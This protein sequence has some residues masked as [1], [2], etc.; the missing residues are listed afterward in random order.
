MALPFI[1][2]AIQQ[3]FSK[4]STENYPAVNREAP[5]H[6]RGRIVFHSDKCI[7][8]GLCERVCAGGAIST[9]KEDTEEGKRITRRFFLGSC[10]FC[11]CCADFC[12]KKAIELST[13][14]HMIARCE[15]DLIVEGT[16]IKKPPAKPPA[17]PADPAAPETAKAPGAVPAADTPAPPVSDKT[18]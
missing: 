3:L 14:Y 4:P 1:K 11:G 2:E 13:D 6:Y 5:E 10:T 8:C 7:D 15:D 9:M 18:E 16:F 12:A 17:K